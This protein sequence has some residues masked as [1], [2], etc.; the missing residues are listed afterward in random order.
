M[1]QPDT[2][3]TYTR[4]IETMSEAIEVLRDEPDPHGTMTL[5]ADR[6]EVEREWVRVLMV[7]G[8]GPRRPPDWLH[9]LER[10]V[11]RTSR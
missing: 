8:E 10:N 7:L 5:L 4:T 1:A 2:L 11:A 9:L 3:E 6:I